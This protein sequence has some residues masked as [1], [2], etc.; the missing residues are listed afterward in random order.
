MRKL[1]IRSLRYIEFAGVVAF[2]IV[3]SLT[4]FMVV[5]NGATSVSG[6]FWQDWKQTEFGPLGPADV[7]ALIKVRQAGLWE[8]PVGQQAQDRAASDDVKDVG[9]LLA[10]DH[11]KLDETVR[12]VAEQLDV[13]LPSLPNP[14]QQVWMDELS[15][16]SGE[17]FD[18]VF[19]NRLRAAHGSVYEAL[20]E[21]RAGTRNELVRSFI[22]SG[23]L[24]VMRHITHLESTGLVEY[25]RLPE[26]LPPERRPA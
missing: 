25:E 12:D 9:A 26:P 7:D 4:I 11:I 5:P 17:E 22:Q 10:A 24:V 1:Q 8:I 21:V 23:L 13:V 20:A 19:V 2:L 18:R 3:S 16:L 15:G 6:V 14:Q